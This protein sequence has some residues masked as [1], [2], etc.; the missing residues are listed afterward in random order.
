MNDK[1]SRY[2]TLLLKINALIDIKVGLIA[3]LANVTAAIKE[4]FEMKERDSF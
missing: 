4:E 1:L 3:N 2:Q